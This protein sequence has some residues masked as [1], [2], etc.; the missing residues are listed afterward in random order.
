[1][2]APGPVIKLATGHVPSRQACQVARVLGARHLAQTALT[3]LTGRPSVFA[4]GAGI[5]AIHATSM[6]F[7]AAADG[8]VRQAALVDA[9]AESALAAGGFSVSAQ[10][11]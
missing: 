1:M 8:S 9:L 5:D 11:V 6:L 2:L 4:A 7:L 3:A 10:R